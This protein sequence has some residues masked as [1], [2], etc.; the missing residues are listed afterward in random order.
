MPNKCFF[1][2]YIPEILWFIFHFIMIF[3]FDLVTIDGTSDDNN[4]GVS[5]NYVVSFKRESW[6]LP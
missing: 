4:L 2:D 5:R 3:F 6:I 1:L